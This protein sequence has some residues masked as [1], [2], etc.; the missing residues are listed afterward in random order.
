ETVHKGLRYWRMYRKAAEIVRR[1][2]RDPNRYEYMDAA[3]LPV[4]EAELGTLDLFHETAG[5]EAAVAR[6][7]KQDALLEAVHVAHQSAA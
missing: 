6:K 5:G 2:E 7:L 1:V 3:I 4:T